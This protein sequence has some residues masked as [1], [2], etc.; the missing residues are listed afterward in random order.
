MHIFH[1]LINWKKD[2]INTIFLECDK[3]YYGVGCKET[4]GH[5]RDVKY[6]LHI[7][8]TCVTG[9]DAGYQEELC[10]TGE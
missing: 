3:G 2:I 1:I 5:C 9:C 4:C 7:N 10:K 6:S 8:G